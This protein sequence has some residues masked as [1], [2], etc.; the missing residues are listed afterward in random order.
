M[1]KDIKVK[2]TKTSTDT[3]TV[4]QMIDRLVTKA[5]SALCAM[6]DFTQEKVD[7]IVHQMAIAGLD[8]HMELAKAAYAET[9][10]GER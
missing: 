1:L 8:H 7:H 10:R 2:T 6:D 3:E 5:H 9:G 4:D